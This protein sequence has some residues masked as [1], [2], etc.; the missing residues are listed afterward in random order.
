MGLNM[1]EVTI[2]PQFAD[3]NPLGYVNNSIVGNWFEVGR[4]NFFRFFTPKLDFENWELILVKNT[5]KFLKHMIFNENVTIKTYVSHI[6]NTSFTLYHEAYQSGE[7]KATG[8][9]VLVNFDFEKQ[10]KKPIK[11]SIKAKLEKHLKT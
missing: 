9:A 2:T 1:F 11:P 8:T 3:I 6:G 10:T 7:L 5:Q 4:N